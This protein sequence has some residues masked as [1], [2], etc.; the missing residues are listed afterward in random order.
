[1]RVETL[2]AFRH[3]TI[4]YAAAHRLSANFAPP[5][6]RFTGGY[7]STGSNSSLPTPHRGQVQS[8]GISSNLVPGAIPPSGSPTAGSYIQPHTTQR[9]FF[10][11]IHSCFYSGRPCFYLRQ[12]RRTTFSAATKI[13]VPMYSC[14]SIFFYD[15]TSSAYS[16][17][18]TGSKAD[19]VCRRSA[20]VTSV[21]PY[22]NICA[23]AWK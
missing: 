14:K 2:S 5:L 11:N 23:A 15:A 21:C 10:I 3:V 12:F 9:Y 20:N 4:A 17:P 1:M 7:S 13:T 19:C 16:Q 8:S 22:Y 18:V 6:R